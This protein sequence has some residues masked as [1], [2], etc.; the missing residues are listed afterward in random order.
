MYDCL[1]ANEK[2]DDEDEEGEDEIHC[3]FEVAIMIQVVLKLKQSLWG[4]NL[5]TCFLDCLSLNNGSE[6][7]IQWPSQ[8][9]SSDLQLGKV[10][11]SRALSF[12]LQ[13]I[14]MPLLN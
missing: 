3:L 11:L 5:D 12:G 14:L 7:A 2:L 1:P 10:Q 4:V 8:T 13:K 6:T 9:G